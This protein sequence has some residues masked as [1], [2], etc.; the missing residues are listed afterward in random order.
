MQMKKETYIWGAGHY[1]VLTA[2][3]LENEGVKV[4]GFIDRNANQIC[5]CGD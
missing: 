3:R 5:T 1:G 4:N 2:L